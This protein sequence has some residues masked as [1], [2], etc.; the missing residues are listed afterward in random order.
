MAEKQDFQERMDKISDTI[1][2]NVLKGI[3]PM[4]FDKHL[5]KSAMQKAI[6]R[7]NVELAGRAALTLWRLDRQALWRRLAIIAVEDLAMGNIDLALDVMV[8]AQTPAAWRKSVGDAALGVYLAQRMA[9]SVKTR[10]LT[11]LY[12]YTDLSKQAAKARTW[13]ETASFKELVSILHDPTK[14]A[15]QQALALFGVFGSRSFGTKNFQRSGGDVTAAIKTV[16][17][18][19]VPKEIL[20]VCAATLGTPHFLL[21]MLLPVGWLE[22]QREAKNLVVRKEAPVSSPVCKGLP[23]CA[24]DGLYT[25]TGIDSIKRLKKAVPGLCR[26]TNEQ[27]GEG[28]FFIEGEGLYP[29]LTCD[30][31]DSFRQNSI[32][33]VMQSLGLDADDYMALHRALIKNY[34]LYNDI[35]LAKIEAMPEPAPDLFGGWK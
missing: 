4:P 35:R 2:H 1:P 17:E 16:K 5:M 34:D 26:Y 14:E 27:I 20:S 11:E 30:R 9:R 29:R 33:A 15:Y 19:A 6:R 18:M 21:A 24:V 7:N 22:M 25:R 13:A 8:V 23:T 31:W 3:Q 10:Y 12:L 32:L 28:F